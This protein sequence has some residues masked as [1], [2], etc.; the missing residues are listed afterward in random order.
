MKNLGI[1]GNFKIVISKFGKNSWKYHGMFLI[2][3]IAYAYYIHSKRAIQ[4]SSK[5]SDWYATLGAAGPPA[6]PGPH[7]LMTSLYQLPAWADFSW[8]YH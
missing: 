1:W 8:I 6:Q 4:I 3:N 5:Y 7:Q 2:V